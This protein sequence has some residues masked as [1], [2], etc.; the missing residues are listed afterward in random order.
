[1]KT[2]HKADCKRVFKHYDITCPRC[3][4]LAGGAEPRKAWFEKQEA[5]DNYIRCSHGAE[6]I[7]PGG[8]CNICGNGRDF[9]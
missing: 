4:E 5:Y 3:Q 2:L 8:Y 1:M 9:S 7:N 6:N